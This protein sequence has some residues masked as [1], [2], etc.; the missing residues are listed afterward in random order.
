[1]T[2]GRSSRLA[3]AVPIEEMDRLL[4]LVVAAI[5]GLGLLMVVSASITAADRELAEFRQLGRGAVLSS[6][7]YHYARLVEIIYAVETMDRLLRDPH[8]LDG[9]VRARARGNRD[10]GIGVAEA[11]RGTLLHH[12]RIDDQ[13]LISWVNLI[14]ATGATAMYLGLESEEAYKGRG[15]SACATCDGFFY[16]GEEIVVVGGGNM[17]SGIAQVLAIAGHDVVASAAIHSVAIVGRVRG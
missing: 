7:H 6:F 13:G 5:V 12:Y 16:R 9:R 1:M 11:P 14:I 17:G 2:A 15:V 4:V 8:I 3:P 10:E